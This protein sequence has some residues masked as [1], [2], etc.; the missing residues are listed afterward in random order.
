MFDAAFP[1][2]IPLHVSIR[3]SYAGAD[4]NDM[5]SEYVRVLLVGVRY[6]MCPGGNRGHRLRLR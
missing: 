2:H 5:M 3:R 6:R 1:L 4:E